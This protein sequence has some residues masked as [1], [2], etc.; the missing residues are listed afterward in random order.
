M[1][2]ISV[3]FPQGE[4]SSTL[5]MCKQ[6]L[7]KRRREMPNQNKRRTSLRFSIE[8]DNTMDYLDSSDIKVL[9]IFNTGNPDDYDVYGSLSDEEDDESDYF[10]E[11]SSCPPLELSLNKFNTKNNILFLKKNNCSFVYLF[12]IFNYYLFYFFN[13]LFF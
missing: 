3:S 12:F 11:R 8:I 1:E 5:E 10:I 7:Y 4:M 2:P 9:G 6:R 13:Y